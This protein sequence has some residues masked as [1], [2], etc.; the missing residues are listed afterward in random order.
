MG[1]IKLVIFIIFAVIFY[2]LI[3]CAKLTACASSYVLRNKREAISTVYNQKD[4]PLLIDIINIARKNNC[5]NF[6]PYSFHELF[7]ALELY[8]L[9]LSYVISH[10]CKNDEQAGKF[11]YIYINNI[12][13]YIK[14]NKPNIIFTAQAKDKNLWLQFEDKS[15]LLNKFL[16]RLEVYAECFKRIPPTIQT[17]E[18]KVL[19]VDFLGDLLS[20][21][22]NYL[23][24]DFD[25]NNDTQ[26]FNT[27]ILNGKQK[28]M[29][30]IETVL[31]LAVKTVEKLC[32]Y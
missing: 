26:L 9:F 4:D 15:I 17:L 11:L 21:F 32:L 10:V 25:N 13:Q 19:Y 23:F 14:S 16:T 7:F 27:I 5:Y 28:A 6:E 29:S 1:L 18:G 2:I 8:I 22:S 20:K 31:V 24:E 12:V 3:G 30:V